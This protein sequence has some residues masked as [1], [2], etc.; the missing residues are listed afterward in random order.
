MRLYPEA[1]QRSARAVRAARQRGVQGAAV[2]AAVA[3]VASVLSVSTAEVAPARAQPLQKWRPSG[4]SDALKDL[5]T[6]TGHKLHVADYPQTGTAL[7]LGGLRSRLA[8]KDAQAWLH[9][10][11]K[12]FGVADTDGMLAKVTDRVQLPDSSGGKHVWYDQSLHGMP[13]YNARLGVHLNAGSP[14]VTA[15]TNGL[16]PDLIPRPRRIRR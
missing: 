14:L 5:Q 12:L 8:G 6:E 2:T 1:G 11:A 3:V 10:H 4:V 13:V 9:A 15:V 7:T 16:R